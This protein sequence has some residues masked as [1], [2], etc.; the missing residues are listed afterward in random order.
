ME[1]QVRDSSI[2]NSPV[3]PLIEHD[4]QPRL[5]NTSEE[6]TCVNGNATATPLKDLFKTLDTSVIH[7]GI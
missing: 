6:A 7:S 2:Q 5:K 3:V 4:T 1:F